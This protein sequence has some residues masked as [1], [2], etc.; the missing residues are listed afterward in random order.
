ME[1]ASGSY[2]KVAMD[3][4]GATAGG[5]GGRVAGKLAA[6]KLGVSRP[7]AGLIV[8][9][10]G[11]VVAKKV[12]KGAGLGMCAAGGELAAEPILPESLQG[13]GDLD[14]R[15]V[16]MIERAAMRGV[17]DE[18]N[19]DSPL[20]GDGDDSIYGDDPLNGDDDD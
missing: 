16:D 4:V 10:L 19:G 11:V 17:E 12:H 7:I 14:V 9:A 5:I 18:M 1:K 3:G 15:D 6:N 20:N 2:L 13:I 8:F